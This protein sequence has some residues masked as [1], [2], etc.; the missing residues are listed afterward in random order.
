ME[1]GKKQWLEK[2]I[3]FH[4]ETNGLPDI[5]R[6]NDLGTPM[7]NWTA[8]GI[9]LVPVTPMPRL[10]FELKP[11][12]PM[13]NIIHRIEDIYPLTIVAMRYGG[14]IVIFEADNH[15]DFISSVQ[16]DEEVYYHVRE[17]MN[18]N[19]SHINYGMGPTL[20][21]AFEDFKLNVK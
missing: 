3:L 16:G 15:C 10:D 8:L 4:R 12:Q 14:A 7:F 20:S 19:W 9:S 2:Y 1:D 18:D 5:V 13:K 6:V 21:D 17:W 11:V